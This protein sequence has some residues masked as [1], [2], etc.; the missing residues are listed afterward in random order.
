MRKYVLVFCII[1]L[2]CFTSGC[3][4]YSSANMMRIHSDSVTV[5]SP[6][7]FVHAGANTDIDLYS[8]RQTCSKDA[9]GS[10]GKIYW[11]N[12]ITIQADSNSN[13]NIGKPSK[14]IPTAKVVVPESTDASILNA[15]ASVIKK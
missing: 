14:A 7:A 3:A 15:A 4:L 5:L 2:F 9:I 8:G 12:V 11:P 10:N 13:L 1:I 6:G